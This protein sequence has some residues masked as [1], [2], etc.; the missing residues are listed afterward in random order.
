MDMKSWNTKK[1]QQLNKNKEYREKFLFFIFK[2]RLWRYKTASGAENYTKT[3]YGYEELKHKKIERLNNNQ[4][5]QGEVM[6]LTHIF[7]L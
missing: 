5:V 2:Y 1:I 6:D 3:L 7:R 4:R